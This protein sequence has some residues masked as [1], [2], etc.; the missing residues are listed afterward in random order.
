M[1]TIQFDYDDA[2]ISCLERRVLPLAGDANL[3]VGRVTYEKEMEFR[4]DRIR[5]GVPFDLPSWDSL[6]K[7]ETN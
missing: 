5:A 3:I 1:K 7:Y 2:G 6:K 4:R